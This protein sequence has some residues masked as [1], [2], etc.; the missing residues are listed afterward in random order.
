MPSGHTL[1]KYP[2]VHG[3]GGV[4]PSKFFANFPSDGTT[5]L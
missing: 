5:Q 2:L 3:G 1:D 4:N